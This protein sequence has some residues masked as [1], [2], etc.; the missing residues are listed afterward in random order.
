M[1]KTPA[2]PKTKPAAAKAAKTPAKAKAAAKPKAAPKSKA[3]AAPA[4]AQPKDGSR[5]VE[6]LNVLQPGK[7][8]RMDAAKYLAACQMLLKVLPSDSVGLTQTEMIAGMRAALP[9][10]LFP[11]STGGWWT[12]AAQL[13]LEARGIIVRDGGKPLRW[14][15]AQ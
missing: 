11:G 8:Y 9:K 5:S 13:D 3:S 2:K 14:R 6:A 4:L 10:A 1:A 15:K 12:K 7:T